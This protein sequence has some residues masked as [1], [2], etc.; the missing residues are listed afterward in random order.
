MA[1]LEVPLEWAAARVAFKSMR[2][3]RSTTQESNSTATTVSMAVN[4]RR[5]IRRR[6]LMA[7]LSVG[8]VPIHARA[9][10][11]YGFLLNGC[12]PF[13]ETGLFLGLFLEFKG[14]AK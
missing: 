1:A 6:S 3:A 8:K 7:I 11:T 4:P 12:K 9:K 2:L 10:F 5:E 14:G 13:F